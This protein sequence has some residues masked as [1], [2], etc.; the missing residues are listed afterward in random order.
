MPLIHERFPTF[1]Q[2]LQNVEQNAIV[3]VEIKYPANAP[4]GFPSRSLLIFNTLKILEKFPQ[5]QAYFSTFEPIV[6]LLLKY[7]QQKY[8]V[9]YL[10]AGHGLFGEIDKLERP[11]LLKWFE[12]GVLFAKDNKLQGVVTFCTHVKLEGFALLA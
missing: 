10:N 11:E 8:P 5:R 2:V 9:Y 12:K 6:C 1:Q 7:C 3:N 4:P